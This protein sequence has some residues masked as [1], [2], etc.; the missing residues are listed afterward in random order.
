[1]SYCCCV[2]LI[3]SVLVKHLQQVREGARCQDPL[4]DPSALHLLSLLPTITAAV[5]AAAVIAAAAVSTAATTVTAATVIP[6]TLSCSFP[7]IT[8]GAATA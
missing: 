7:N 2:D 4:N 6:S 1:M 5:I 3:F 8:A